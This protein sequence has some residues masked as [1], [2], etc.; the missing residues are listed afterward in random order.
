MV[1][2][3]AS[4]LSQNVVPAIQNFTIVKR[5]DN[6]KFWPN[7][8]ALSCVQMEYELGRFEPV[9]GTHKIMPESYLNWYWTNIFETLHTSILTVILHVCSIWSFRTAAFPRYWG[10]E[11]GRDVLKRAKI[12]VATS[13]LPITSR[14]ILLSCEDIELALCIIGTCLLSTKA[15]NAPWDCCD[16]PSVLSAPENM[17]KILGLHPGD[18]QRGLEDLGSLIEYK[19]DDISLRVLHASL[20]DFVSDLTQFSGLPFS[21]AVAIYTDLAIWC[22]YLDPDHDQ[23]KDLHG[24]SAILYHLFLSWEKVPWNYANITH[25]RQ[26]LCWRSSIPQ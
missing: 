17:E 24:E 8:E 25:L 10:N 19:G 1:I 18:V 22:S 13:L 2:F 11:P 21:L 26:N 23:F 16:F 4:A 9:L 3:V 12:C 5:N 14:H 20:F 15:T 6:S 7:F